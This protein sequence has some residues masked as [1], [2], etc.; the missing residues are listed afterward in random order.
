MQTVTARTDESRHHWQAIY[1]AGPEESLGWFQES[2]T[3]SL[4]LIRAAGVGPDARIIDVGGGASRLVDCLLERGHAH[5]SVLDIAA[6]ALDRARARLGRRAERVDWVIADV[7]TW[8]PPAPF[9][10][11]HDRAVFHFLTDAADRRRYRATLAAALRSGGH[12]I[13]ATFAADGPERCSGLPVRR[14]GPKML[15]AEL[16]EAFVLDES[17][18]E[19][20][21]TP[22]GL[23]QKYIY[24]RFRRR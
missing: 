7:T 18:H 20:H 15:A 13:I 9:D 21:I 1:G 5:L 4:M 10:L 6:P 16:G 24:C 23:V 2:P 12:A 19:D 3:L 14:Y 8:T 17:R 22:G 11:W